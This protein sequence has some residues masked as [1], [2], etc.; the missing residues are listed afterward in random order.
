[1]DAIDTPEWADNPRLRTWLTA[2]RDA[3]PAW[4]AE[5]GGGWD[6][7]PASLDRLEELVRS[8]FTTWQEADGARDTTLLQ[9]AAWY[10][11]EVQVRHCGARW[12][13]DPDE[14]ERP[15]VAG[16]YP[17]VTVPRTELT[18]AEQYRLAR[19]EEEDGNPTPVVD[20]AA[21]I[22]ALFTA[23]DSHLREVI[24]WFEH[25]REWLGED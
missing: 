20:P 21:R 17:L 5:H 4:S 16:G 19:E 10:L 8:R 22:R 14:P 1:M 25:F 13:C 6:F 24:D 3:F 12:R 7:T 15:P 9:V 2:G 18:D 11:G 23:Q